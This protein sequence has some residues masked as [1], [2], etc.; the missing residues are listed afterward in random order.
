MEINFVAVLVAT[1]AMFATGAV[2]YMAFFSKQWG[3]IHGFEKLSK[4]E[5]KEMQAQM[6]PYYGAQLVVTLISAWALAYFLVALPGVAWYVTAFILWL[7]FIVPTEVS[8]VIFGGTEGKWILSKIAISI[9]GSLAATL[10]GAWVIS[11]F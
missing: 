5:Q 4:K 11:L 9:G 10:V 3:E 7:G 1:I 8:S 2:W 6:G